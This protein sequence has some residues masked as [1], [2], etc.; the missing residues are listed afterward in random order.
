VKLDAEPNGPVSQSATALF[1]TWRMP[2][3]PMSC[4]AVSST[5]P[6]PCTRPEPRLPPDM[7]SGCGPS[8]PMVS[9]CAHWWAVPFSAQPNASIHVH[10]I[11]EKPS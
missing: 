9:G 6:K 7:F 1:L 4:I 5:W 3:V 8:R 10:T 11:G 2:A